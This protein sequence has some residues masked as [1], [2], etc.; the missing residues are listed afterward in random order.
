MKTYLDCV[1]CFFKQAL[2]AAKLAKA[3]RKIQKKVLDKLSS[4][5]PEFSFKMSPPYMGRIIYNIV[6]K[7]TKSKDPFLKLKRRSNKLALELYPKLKEKVRKAKDSLLMATEL[8]CMGNIIDFGVK[9]S[10]DVEKEVDDF[11]KGN[12][13]IHKLYNKAV[14]SY[15]EFKEFLNRANLILYLADNSGEVVFDRLL[16]EEIKNKWKDKQIFYA[17]KERPIINDALREDA[18]FCGMNKVAE[19]ISSGCDSPGTILEFS[20]QEFLKIYKKADLIISK[21]QGN[22]E[23]LSSKRRPIFFLFRAKCPVVAWHLKCRVG[24]IILKHN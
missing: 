2:E 5:L 10:L 15:K 11:L 18:F 1:P 24:D 19:V 14:F 4:A 9:N 20:S 3:S 17:V 7:E 21:G 22:F 12:F 8:A 6:K 13:D 23:A 16:I